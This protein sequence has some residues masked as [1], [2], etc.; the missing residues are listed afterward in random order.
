MHSQI[1]HRLVHVVFVPLAMSGALRADD[2]PVDFASEIRPIL[3]DRC[4]F[5]HGPDEMTREAELRLD[6][7]EG[8]KSPLA[9]DDSLHAVVSG[10]PGESE[11]MRRILS[12]DPD[13]RMPPAESAD[14]LTAEEKDLIRRWI[15]QGARWENH[16]A[17]EPIVTPASPTVTAA[18]WCRS[19]IDRFVLARLEA[20]GLTPNGPASK[21]R[22]IRRVTFDLTG[23][24]PT[25][26][27]IDD[28]LADDSPG[29]YEKVVD[30]LLNTEHYGERMAAEWLDV[31]RYSDTYGY[32]VD[33][34][35]FVW[36]WRDWVVRAF[37]SNMPYDTFITEQLAG[38]MLPNATQDQRLATT[39]NRL[40]P[41]KVE[42]GSVP[43]EFRVEY[44]SDRTQTVATAF[45][46]L[47]FECCRC[48]D[49]KYDP[50]SQKEYY[51]LFSFFN[52]IDEA[53][54]YSYFTSSVPTPTMRMPSETQSAQLG[55]T[56][57][58]GDGG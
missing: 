22:L 47:T 50:I 41:Q 43:E 27:E 5:C 20:A 1:I 10:K 39:F 24:P 38:D 19:E 45:M 23:L 34:D 28:F 29:A 14:E 21:A 48:H 44:V 31:A 16:W 11:L 9:S 30:R 55:A 54:L 51:Q 13:E 8:I 35:R 26:K 36:P 18:E 56:S 12:E 53:G 7:E 37:N 40:H 57:D 6:S 25:L 2:Q 15:Q 49:H 33:R 58:A 52:N 46:G 32:Q 17:F 3:S 4:F 42:G